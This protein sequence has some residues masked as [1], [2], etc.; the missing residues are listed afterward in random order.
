MGRSRLETVYFFCTFLD[1]AVNLASYTIGITAVA[2]HRV[3]LYTYF[4]YAIAIAVFTGILASYIN[5]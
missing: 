3:K 1:S 2:T 4:S 5:A